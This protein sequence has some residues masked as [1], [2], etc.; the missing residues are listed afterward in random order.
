MLE[1]REECCRGGGGRE[2]RPRGVPN[3]PTDETFSLVLSS[4]RSRH[5]RSKTTRYIAVTAAHKGVASTRSA[6]AFGCRWLSR[7]VF[8]ATS[9]SSKIPHHVAP[10]G[11]AE[12]VAALGP[13]PRGR[14]R[15]HTELVVGC[16]ATVESKL[17]RIVFLH[18]ARNS[19]HPELREGGRT[20]WG[21]GRGNSDW[22]D[23]Q[24]PG[25]G[26]RLNALGKKR[27]DNSR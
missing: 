7:G 14:R 12:G 13:S 18:H 23:T 25:S 6:L 1:V 21:R 20:A 24:A 22:S 8:R 10:R 27:P 11:I 15:T 5:A 4:S 3:I 19:Q 9:L 17:Q 26:V 16:A 2:A